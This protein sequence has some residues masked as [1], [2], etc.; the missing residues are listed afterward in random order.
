MMDAF[1]SG[2]AAWFST[3]ALLGTL[4]FLLRLAMLLLGSH[5]LH[6]GDHSVGHADSHSHHADSGEAFRLLTLE[7]IM[8]F[9]MGIGWGGLAAFKSDFGLGWSLFVG[10]GC[11][12]AML[13]LQA[14]LLQSMYRL[15]A[16][17]NISI[18]DALGVHGV[19]YVSIPGAKRGKGQVTL[20]VNQK[21]RQF[22][23]IT[24]G[25]DLPSQTRIRVIGVNDDNT[26]TVQ[27]A[28]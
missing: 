20:I 2:H 18:Q 1:F 13:W 10:L 8:A 28:G 15:Q 23:A 22:N 11:G 17:G 27:Q 9:F 5:G 7:G 12:L 19:V 3:L 25:D 6:L 16:S 14:L 26:V 4:I 24:P 21:Q